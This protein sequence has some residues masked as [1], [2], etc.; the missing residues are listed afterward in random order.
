MEFFRKEYS[1]AIVSAFRCSWIRE[2]SAGMTAAPL[3]SC[4]FMYQEPEAG[5]QHIRQNRHK[6]AKSWD[7]HVDNGDEGAL[8]RWILLRTT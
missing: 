3:N 2:N 7:T 4:E 8:A 6:L 5:W 1:E